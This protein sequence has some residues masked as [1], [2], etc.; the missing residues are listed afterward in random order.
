MLTIA[1]PAPAK[2][3]R[4]EIFRSS[5]MA[6]PDFHLP[7]YVGV[8]CIEAFPEVNKTEA[9]ISRRATHIL[10]KERGPVETILF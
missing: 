3:A 8:L 9:E 5:C 6:P 1:P 7:T 10:F 4:L 2:K